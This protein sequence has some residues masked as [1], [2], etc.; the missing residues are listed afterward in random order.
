MT[1]ENR[2]SQ[3]VT[4]TL[5]LFLI[6]AGLIGISNPD[7]HWFFGVIAFIG[8]ILLLISST[9]LPAA[10]NPND[11]E[12]D[13][14]IERKFTKEGLLKGFYIF[15]G[16]ILYI[17]EIVNP[18][19]HDPI[20]IFKNIFFNPNGFIYCLIFTLVSSIYAK[21]IGRSTWYG[22]FGMLGIIGLIIV[23]RLTPNR[24]TTNMVYHEKV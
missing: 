21:L 24:S 1:I 6:F 10:V 12:F 22:L 18:I 2:T 17:V 15:T 8:L 14:P 13:F 20:P 3:F 4:F 16:I 5:G 11:D 23:A 7:T 9:L 19:P